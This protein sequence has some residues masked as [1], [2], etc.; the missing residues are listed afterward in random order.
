MSFETSSGHDDRFIIKTEISIP[1]Y[2]IV[3]NNLVMN[4]NIGSQIS[5]TN[6]KEKK[7][8]QF[9]SGCRENKLKKMDKFC[10]EL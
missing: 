8:D 5:I 9:Y 10:F 6:Q 7:N 2:P 4:G 1:R 3:K